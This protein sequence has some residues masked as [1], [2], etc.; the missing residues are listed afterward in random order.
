MKTLAV[1][2]GQV[3]LAMTLLVASINSR[4]FGEELASITDVDQKVHGSSRTAMEHDYLVV[5][6]ASESCPIA[7]SYIPALNSLKRDFNE[8]KFDYVIVHTNKS[9]SVE[10]AK[11]HAKEFELKWSVALDPDQAIAKSYDAKVSP[12]AFVV[13][14]KNSSIVY[15]GR[16]DDRFPDYGKKKP[17]ASR[18]DLK[19]ALSELAAGKAVSVPET[20]A[21]G[22]LIRRR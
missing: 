7:N 15:R 19:V 5:I 13:D 10:E 11:N 12:E 17:T 4:T 21:V 14:L 6:F 20:K 2:S 8:A 9:L 16:I 18:E 1:I 22:C 3:V